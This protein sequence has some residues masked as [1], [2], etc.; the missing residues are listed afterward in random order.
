MTSEQIKAVHRM[1]T[2]LNPPKGAMDGP[3][4]QALKRQRLEMWNNFVKNHGKI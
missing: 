4:Y 3:S 1:N 2:F